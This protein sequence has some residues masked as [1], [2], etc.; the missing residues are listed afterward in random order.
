MANAEHTYIRSTGANMD[1]TVEFRRELRALC[2][3]IEHESLVLR[4][5][6]QVC[7]QLR[8]V[9]VRH[10]VA[11]SSTASAHFFATT[12][13]GQTA[14]AAY[15]VR[16][17]AVTQ[18]GAVRMAQH[19]RE[20]TVRQVSVGAQHVVLC[21]A[22][23]RAFGIGHSGN[24]RL[25]FRGGGAMVHNPV[26]IRLPAVAA[27]MKVAAG[28]RHTLVL[29]ACGTCFSFGY[30]RGGR[31]GHG[32]PACTVFDPRAI[33][34]LPTVIDIAAGSSHSLFALASGAAVS[35]GSGGDGRLGLGR[36]VQRAFHPT[37]VIGLR[38][39]YIFAVA[40]S[41]PAAPVE[42]DRGA[43]S[44]FLSSAGNVFGAGS[45]GNAPLGIRERVFARLGY[46]V[47]SRSCYSY[48]SSA[49]SINSMAVVPL[50]VPRGTRITSMA[51]G[52]DT[53]A[54][55]T[56][57]GRLCS[58]GVSRRPG[59]RSREV[60]ARGVPPASVLRTALAEGRVRCCGSGNQL[61]SM[62]LPPVQPELPQWEAIPP[63]S[64]EVR[65]V[66]FVG[67]DLLSWLGD[68]NQLCEHDANANVCSYSG[69]GATTANV[70]PNWQRVQ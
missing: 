70:G 5:L 40:A 46:T 41:S 66:S 33:R 43:H 12:A 35:C 29:A 68:A 28:G 55:I 13:S 56:E 17:C 52:H 49:R 32:K 27:A 15:I 22:G 11:R 57:D 67:A 7:R 1:A 53:T 9:F 34:A 16:A 8:Q 3:A 69:D 21:C 2:V 60:W 42:A 59:C 39:H 62:L 63:G 64:P 54:L 31:L 26:A 30:G 14:A 36:G 10:L 37:R 25:G 45:C 44:L 65:G 6:Q 24:G 38:Q 61:A 47:F 4:Q 19:L 51:A 48:C 23:G 58:F 20:H 50:P 18:L